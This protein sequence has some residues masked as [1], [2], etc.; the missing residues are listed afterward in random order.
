[1]CFV[2]N[3]AILNIAAVAATN[4][5]DGFLLERLAVK[6]GHVLQPNGNTARSLWIRPCIRNGS[7]NWQHDVKVSACPLFGRAW[8]LQES[9]LAARTL[10]YC[11]AGMHF[12]CRAGQMSDDDPYK[13]IEQDLG[14]FSGT[15]HVIFSIIKVKTA[16]LRQTIY[17]DYAMDVWYRLLA[18]YSAKEILL[19]KDKLPAVAGLAFQIGSITGDVYLA[20]LWQR[21]FPEALC[22]IPRRCTDHLCNCG[23][24][25]PE[26]LSVYTAPSWSWASLSVPFS[27]CSDAFTTGKGGL[28]SKASDN[29]P[30]YY[31]EPARFLWDAILI[32]ARIDYVSDSYGQVK[33]GSII[34]RGHLL[35]IDY[36]NP[37]GTSYIEYR[38]VFKGLEIGVFTLDPRTFDKRLQHWALLLGYEDSKEE[39]ESER[40][41][42]LRV[43]SQN[44]NGYPMRGR[45]CTGLILV[46]MED[47]VFERVAYFEQFKAMWPSKTTEFIIR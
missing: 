38:A 15:E 32:E 11:P 24:C 39:K 20:G 18:T 5:D 8:V 46:E 40:A 3:N 23:I 19:K 28:L 17:F 42:R 37:V 30:G 14:V 2:Y 16:V 25:N 9:I 33:G 27:Y 41:R 7:C 1:M 34:I 43:E 31:R 21:N 29:D 12:R 35:K 4:G 26:Q 36:L 6:L 44:R 45:I 47:G 22:W 10:A 13:N